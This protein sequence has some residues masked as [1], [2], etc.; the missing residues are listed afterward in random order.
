MVI[1]AKTT[2]RDSD[3]TVLSQSGRVKNVEQSRHGQGRAQT[4]QQTDDQEN[5]KPGGPHQFF[6]ETARF[7]FV[8]GNIRPSIKLPIP[9]DAE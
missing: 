5:R 4:K 1:K 2:Q 8:I 6:D 9:L 7:F 3:R